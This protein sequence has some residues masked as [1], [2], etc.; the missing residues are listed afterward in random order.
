MIRDA[1]RAA[2]YARIGKLAAAGLLWVGGSAL[3]G[4]GFGIAFFG[5]PAPWKGAAAFALWAVSTLMIGG[6]LRVA[7][8]WK[9][10]P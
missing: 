2:R 3:F 1:K 5:D 10:E 8:L 6:A 7:G 9:G 4:W